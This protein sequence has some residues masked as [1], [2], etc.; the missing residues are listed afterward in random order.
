MKTLIV[1]LIVCITS[2]AYAAQPDVLV[3]FFGPDGIQDKRAV[4]HGEM[5]E[6]YIDRTTLGEELPKKVQVSFRKLKESKTNAVYAALVKKDNQTQDWYAFLVRVDKV[7]KLRAVRTLAL[8]GLFSMVLKGLAEKSS[9]SEE[10]EWQ[11]QNMLLT[12]S[13]DKALK[14]YLKSNRAKFD[15][16]VALMKTGENKQAEATSKSMFVE[17]QGKEEGIFKLLIGGIMDNSVGYLFV[18]PGESPPKM[19]PQKYIYVEQIIEG[20]YIYKAT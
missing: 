12:S 16:I 11:Y 5:L 3:R 19:S 15:K 7:W 17:V 9:R 1:V 14:N 20:W 2:D 10:E 4:Y 13:G 8:P 6:H 18:P